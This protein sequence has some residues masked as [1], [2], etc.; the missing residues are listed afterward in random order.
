[1]RKYLF[2]ILFSCWHAYAENSINIATGEY[3]P[4]TGSQL[5]DDGFVNHIIR[6]A[7]AT[8]GMQVSFV[9]LPWKRS[10]HAAKLG[11]FD[12]AS[13]WVCESEYQKHF[14]CSDE[15]YQGELKMYFR[16]ETP[17]PNWEKLKDLQPY[18]IGATLGYEYVPE[19]H[20]AIKNDELDV[21]MVSNDQLN[22][23]MLLNNRVDLILLNETVM[24]TL[25][26]EQFSTEY[27]KLLQAHPKPFL[28]YRA[29]V[30]FP[31]VLNNSPQ[32][33][34]AFNSGLQQLKESGELSK[35]WQRM[36]RGDFSKLNNKNKQKT[37]S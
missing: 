5:V 11:Q 37:Q 31:K 30:L 6:L 24:E 35:Q 23:N 14:Y 19:F 32:L 29:Q 3:P 2:L 9:Y 28:K 25:L 10:F 22:L 36:I 1:M 15:I 33:R 13:Y 16:K 4:F 21:L 17:L 26:K 27:Q 12:M 8:Q 34:K 20:K 18:R 7:F